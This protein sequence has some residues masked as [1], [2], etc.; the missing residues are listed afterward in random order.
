MYKTI[1]AHKKEFSDVQLAFSQLFDIE[2]ET[3]EFTQFRTI[4]GNYDADPRLGNWQARVMTLAYHCKDYAKDHDIKA[5]YSTFR[6]PKHS[7]GFRTISAPSEELKD[8]QRSVINA[9]SM[10]PGERHPFVN[11]HNCAYAYVKGRSARHAVQKHQKA[12]SRWFL[13]IDLK[14][15]FPSW[16]K[17]LLIEKLQLC[18]PLNFLYQED[19]SNLLEVCLLDNTLPQGSPASPWLS[20]LAMLDTDHRIQ[21]FLHDK[22]FT[23]TRYADDLLISHNYK[24]DDQAILSDIEKI[25]NDTNH[26]LLIINRD[27]VRF[28]SSA[29][30]NWNLGVMLNKDNQ[31]TVGHQKK[32]TLHAE[33]NSMVTSELNEEPWSQ[34]EKQI[35]QGKLA[36]LASIE[37]R[38]VVERMFHKYNTKYHINTEQL[39]KN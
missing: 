13:K 21:K 34:N 30:R 19:L 15:F 37:G 3:V 24:F 9:L 23:Y 22:G 35:L 2:Y 10:Q 28:G 29:G 32:K 38:G 11:A 39:L 12:Q 26:G 33:L 7:G 14:N 4:R 20:N 31:M 1:I 6:I 27:K 5:E 8:L 36:Y 17:E 25:I 18:W 16:T